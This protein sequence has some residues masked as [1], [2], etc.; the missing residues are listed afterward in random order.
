MESKST[1]ENEP[2]KENGKLKDGQNNKTVNSD[3]N[4]IP[5]SEIDSNKNINEKK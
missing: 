4:K 5:S 3:E 1:N 2:S